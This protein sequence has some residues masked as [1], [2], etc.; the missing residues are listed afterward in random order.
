MPEGDSLRRAAAAMAPVLEGRVVTGLWFRKL[1]GHRPRVGDTVHSVEAVGKY[2]LI[3]FDRDLVLHTHLGMSGSWRTAPPEAPVPNTPKLRVVI[4]TA[5]G[6]AWC[7][8]APTVETHVLGARDAPT[9]RLGPDLSDD[10]VDLQQIVGRSRAGR[11]ASATLAELLLDQQVAAGVGNVFKSE[12]LF[13]ARLHPFTP[14]GDVD[15]ATL[16]GLWGIAH[17]MLVTNRDRPFRKTT[18]AMSP[19][20]TF[21]YDRFRKPCRRCSDSILFSPAGERTS[22]STYWCPRCQPVLGRP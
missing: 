9:D 1:R 12:A 15:D 16:A 7:F 6:Q 5:A 11:T 8:A 4:A 21:V 13:V 14:V 3:R 2:L 10:D 18:G 17:E 19:D 20:R 22:R